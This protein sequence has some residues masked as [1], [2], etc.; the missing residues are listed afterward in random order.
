MQELDNAL[1]E[2]KFGRFHLRLLASG[3]MGTVANV[4]VSNTGYL[5]PNAE[6]DLK[7]NLV[8]KGLLNAIPYIGQYKI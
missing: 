4:L 6:C 8:Q 1:K 5:L 2:C 3:L 7:M